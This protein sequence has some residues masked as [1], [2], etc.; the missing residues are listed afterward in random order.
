MFTVHDFLDLNGER[1]PEGMICVS[2]YCGTNYSSAV[3]QD[4]GTCLPLR[5]SR[6]WD[7]LC[8]D[9]ADCACKREL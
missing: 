3:L 9:A 1:V 4:S 2:V 8:V 7:S 5:A 6:T